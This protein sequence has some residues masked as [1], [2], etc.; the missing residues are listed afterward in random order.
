MSC[1]AKVFYPIIVTIVLTHPITEPVWIF[2][3]KCFTLTQ[4]QA[5]LCVT[6]TGNKTKT[7][8]ETYI[9][10]ISSEDLTKRN[11]KITFKASRRGV[12]CY[13]EKS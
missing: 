13:K 2:P 1:V 9:P 8:T 11:S 3:S 12:I 4:T 6:P 5:Y 7:E 10:G